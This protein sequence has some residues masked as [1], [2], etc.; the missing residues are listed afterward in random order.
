[1]TAATACLMMN[2]IATSVV[3]QSL[4]VVNIDSTIENSDDSL[5]VEEDIILMTTTTSME[6]DLDFQEATGSTTTEAAEAT[7]PKRK[8]TGSGEGTVVSVSDNEDNDHDMMTKTQNTVFASKLPESV[9]AGSFFLTRTTTNKMVVHQNVDNVHHE[10][11]NKVK[12]VVAPKS[13]TSSSAVFIAPPRPTTMVSSL[14]TP[15]QLNLIMCKIVDQTMYARKDALDAIQQ[16]LLWSQ[17]GENS[18]EFCRQFLQ[19][20]GFRQV[21]YFLEDLLSVVVDG[22]TTRNDADCINS[23]LDL[24]LV[25]TKPGPSD[26]SS[27]FDMRLLLAKQVVDLDG[28][29]H[30]LTAFN[31]H[32]FSSSTI[33]SSS[34]PPS[35]TPPIE[36]DTVTLASSSSSTHRQINVE[37]MNGSIWNSL[38][39]MWNCDDNTTYCV[40]DNDIT[41]RD[42][43]NGLVRGNQSLERDVVDE[44]ENPISD[45]IQLDMTTIPH[46]SSAIPALSS[47]ATT[48]VTLGNETATKAIQLLTVVVSHSSSVQANAV[49]ETICSYL[50][51]LLSSM[52]TTSLETLSG[53][54]DKCESLVACLMACMVTATSLVVVGSTCTDTDHQQQSPQMVVSV[55][56]N[57][58]Q[59]FPHHNGIHKICY[60]VLQ[61]ACPHLS[62]RE[63]KQLG[64]VGVL[65]AIVASNTIHAD[66]K[67]IA[68]DILEEHFAMAP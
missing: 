46:P 14:P 60:M 32:V 66:V 25:L 22:Q 56:V 51:T 43:M 26:D 42:C 31:Q 37:S 29:K 62:K 50:P 30:I 44:K 8:R 6:V 53:G 27:V 10:N 58:M 68:D 12:T 1:M 7:T 36:S 63:M 40:L 3:Q 28:I 61:Q 2:A 33:E 45:E 13:S 5:M 9:P 23:V 11:V 55:T 49:L 65:G 15:R 54:N 59:H 18:I 35:S 57:V 39:T 52:T 16:L 17:M 67:S 20:G 19:F 38:K 41:A 64:V 34:S 47:S 4:S 24:F 48:V 21:M